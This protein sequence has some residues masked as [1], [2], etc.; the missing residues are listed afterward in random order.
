V[1]IVGG[2]HDGP[3]VRLTHSLDRLDFLNILLAMNTRPNKPMSASGA[4][5][6]LIRHY[7]KNRR[8]LFNT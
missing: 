6:C 2:D 4:V 3:L 7:K 8:W 5:A 1:R